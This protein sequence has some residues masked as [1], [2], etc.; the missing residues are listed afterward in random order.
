MLKRIADRFYTTIGDEIG[1]DINTK[2]V[3]FE[4]VYNWLQQQLTY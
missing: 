3:S 1:F 4:V 2:R